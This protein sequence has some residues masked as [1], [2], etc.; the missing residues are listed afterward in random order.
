MDRFEKLWE[1]NK[2]QGKG[3]NQDDPQ[4]SGLSNWVNGSLFTRFLSTH[5][6]G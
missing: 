4:V 5:T 3:K 1:Q 6:L 2:W